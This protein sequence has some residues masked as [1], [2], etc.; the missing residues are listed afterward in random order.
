MS[1][2]TAPSVLTIDGA[3]LGLVLE[4][5]LGEHFHRPCHMVGLEYR[6]FASS[7]SSPLWE[8]EA[9]LDDGIC[10]PLLLKD[11]RRH[12]WPNN[13]QRVR[14]EFLYDPLREIEV[15]H[16]LLPDRRLG[17]ALCY[18]TVVNIA[19]D[20]YWLFLEKVSGV[21][22]YRIG[23]FRV[24]QQVATWLGGF[25]A[26]LAGEA[27]PQAVPARLLAYDSEYY[28]TW[29]HRALAFAENGAAGTS[30]AARSFLERL[31][32]DYDRVIQR[33]LNLPVTIIHGEF[34]A[35][36]V[37]VQPTGDSLRVCAV[38]WET[39]AVG[40]G[41]MDLAALTSGN[42]T[43][44]QRTCLVRAYQ[45]G[46]AG[47]GGHPT[48]SEELLTALAY[49]RLHLAVQWLGWARDWKPPREHAQDWL[50]EAQRL[51]QQIQL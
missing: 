2:Q 19:A 48:E 6:P 22:L 18:G 20:R 28:R 1:Q 21:E 23:D 34:Y 50:G 4:R 37:L 46:L 7:S 12:S 11:L 38:D 39:A 43:D 30:T 49:C 26:H 5:V 45:D 33:L 27:G 36:N 32:S 16:S 51:V 9:N 47:A 42:W 17:T 14:P 31:A 8:I 44:E 24:W 10:L 25:H 3:Y 13:V 40:P 35:S 41:L 15:Y 29:P